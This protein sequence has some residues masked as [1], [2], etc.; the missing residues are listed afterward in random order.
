MSQN[1]I[2]DQEIGMGGGG[3]SIVVANNIL[4]LLL[5]FLKKSMFR[6]KFYFTEKYGKMFLGRQLLVISK[7]YSVILCWWS[8]WSLMFVTAVLD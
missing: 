4:L 7:Y 1:R 8:G 3:G 6:T 2:E 5:V